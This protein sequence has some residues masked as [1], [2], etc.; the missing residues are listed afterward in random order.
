MT[1]K[2]ELAQWRALGDLAHLRELVEAERAGRLVVLPDGV[3]VNAL[4][5]DL[6]H[7]ERVENAELPE[8]SYCTGDAHGFW[9]GEAYVLRK[10]LAREEAE[11]AL[12]KQKGEPHEADTV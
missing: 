5:E 9:S 8:P 7:A 12:E 1:N 10:I 6:L 3:T 11:A 2:E 4:R